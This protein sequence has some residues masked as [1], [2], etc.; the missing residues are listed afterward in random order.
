M[1]HKLMIINSLL[2]KLNFLILCKENYNK[3]MQK[4]HIVSKT[5]F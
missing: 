3:P 1:N 2:R 5:N 4:F